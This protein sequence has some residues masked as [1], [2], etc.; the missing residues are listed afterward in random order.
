MRHIINKLIAKLSP[1]TI[2]ILIAIMAVA[3]IP[4]AVVFAWGPARATFTMEQPASYVTFDSITNNPKYGDE[5]NFMRV[6]DI[7][8]NDDFGDTEAVTAGKEYE[9]LVFYHNNASSS[10]NEG[11]TGIAHGAYTRAEIPAIVPNGGTAT[12]AAAYITAANANPTTVYDTIDFTNTTGTDMAMRYVPGSTTIHNFGS[13]NGQTLGDTILSGSGV[14]LG[15]NALDGDLPGCNDF[16]G[17]VLFR[18]KA[19]QPNFTFSKEVRISGTTGWQKSIVAK[20]GD[21]LDYLLSYENTGTTAQNDVVLKD[22]LPQGLAYVPGSSK[23][24]NDQGDGVAIPDGVEKDGVN[25]GNYGAGANAFL[26]FSATVT[27]QG[28]ETLVNTADVETNNGSLDNSASVRVSTGGCTPPPAALPTTGPVEIISG[29]MGIA[30]ITLGVVYY[31]KSRKDLTLALHS[32]QSQPT[33]ANGKN[34]EEVEHK[35]K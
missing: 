9:V 1:K 12:D 2:G 23:L 29:L 7:A 24:T 16:S 19:E 33:A 26:A 4:T 5:R 11:G 31:M 20:P 14:P 30:A 3:T 15:Y 13:T 25:I 17:Y 32:A 28:C 6:R 27:T 21:K 34:E 35:D 8:A 18:V 22:V 10:L